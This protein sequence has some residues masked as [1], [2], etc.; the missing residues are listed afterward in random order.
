M[1]DELCIPYSAGILGP[2][3]P[4]RASP[5]PRE[6]TCFE[7]QAVQRHYATECPSRFVRVRGEAPPGWKVDSPGRAAKDE[8]AW[9]GPELTDA[10]R[11]RYREFITKAL[12]F[13]LPPHVAFPFTVD[14]IVR[15][16][17]VANRRLIPR[18]GRG[19]GR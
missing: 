7:C 1:S 17:P 3:S 13:S 9:N 8:S 4:C 2:F 5:Y 12:K 18:P 11:A 16:A 10:A 15:P 14:D 19:R 6:L